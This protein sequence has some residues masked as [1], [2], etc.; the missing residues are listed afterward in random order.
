MRIGY[1]HFAFLGPSSQ[2]SA[3]ASECAADQGAFWEYHDKI[4]ASL[5][6]QREQLT[7]ERLKTFA[8]DLGLDAEA[9]GQCLDS[10][11]YSDHV[12]QQSALA[13]QLG[14]QSTPAFLINGTAML[15]AQPFENF[16]Q[17]IDQKAAE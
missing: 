16:K 10:G 4:Y 11:K 9:F 7:K 15:G 12:L 8:A 6:A 2:W 1:W 5:A 14:V 13:R 17:I 3:E